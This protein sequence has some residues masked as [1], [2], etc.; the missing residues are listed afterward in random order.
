MT[1]AKFLVD[2]DALLNESSAETAST[3]VSLFDRIQ[4]L[5]KSRQL[6]GLAC[7]FAL[8]CDASGLQPQD[9]FSASR[10]LMADRMT[11]SGMKPHFE[12]MKFHLSTD[13]LA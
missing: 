5:P 13:I 3:C 12:A 1:K 9:V 2:R 7:A 10:N 4:G 11:T 8:M 6:M